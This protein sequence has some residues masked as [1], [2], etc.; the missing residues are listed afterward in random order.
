MSNKCRMRLYQEMTSSN[1]ANNTNLKLLKKDL[2]NGFE[3]LDNN[4]IDAIPETNTNEESIFVKIEEP[5]LNNDETLD[6]TLL[7][8]NNVA[9]NISPKMVEESTL[10]SLKIR[11]VGDI[12][13]S[14]LATPRRAKKA[15]DKAMMKI[16]E[17]RKK[18]KV[19]Q[20]ASNRFKK[21]IKCLKD[22][23]RDK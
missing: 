23:L 1:N 14:H 11:Y 12:N 10:K 16:I 18:I 17:Q 3:Y 13:A 5:E 21:K 15:L 8:Q 22:L 6:G 7:V 20:R 9:E 19:L 2:Y 4:K